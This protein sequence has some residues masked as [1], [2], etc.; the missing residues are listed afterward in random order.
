MKC[1]VE[2]LH[3]VT[4]LHENIILAVSE[5]LGVI[6]HF[7]GKSCLD[8]PCGFADDFSR[9]FFEVATVVKEKQS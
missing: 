5:W 3:Y 9:L 7:I 8:H 1:I 2:C 4:L 6:F